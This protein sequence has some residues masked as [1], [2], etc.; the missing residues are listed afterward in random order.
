M[1]TW[2]IVNLHYLCHGLTIYIKI[3]SISHLRPLLRPLDL[4]SVY[5]PYHKLK[6]SH[7]HFTRTP[8]ARQKKHKTRNGMTSL[9]SVIELICANFFQILKLPIDS[10]YT[11]LPKTVS[12]Q[13]LSVAFR[14]PGRS[15]VIMI[16]Q[17]VLSWTKLLSVWCRPFQIRTR[18]SRENQHMPGWQA[19]VQDLL[20]QLRRRQK[21]KA[22][23]RRE[24]KGDLYQ[25]RRGIE[26][27]GK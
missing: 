4:S 23:N 22:D 7:F 3:K 18:Q 9:C 2:A 6:L 17:N 11:I 25:M 15:T 12:R 27:R 8:Y 1:A 14:D 21:L 26:W 20:E 13:S 10:S 19:D 16:A 24:R 5:K